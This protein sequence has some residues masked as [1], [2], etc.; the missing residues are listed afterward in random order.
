MEWNGETNEMNE[1]RNR[2]LL[3]QFYVFKY[4]NEIDDNESGFDTMFEWRC[5]GVGTTGDLRC[6]HPLRSAPPIIT[7]IFR[8]FYDG[9][10][11]IYGRNSFHGDSKT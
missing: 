5:S 6:C 2:A 11:R 1:R 7:S 8:G 9:G 10:M 3:L 4:G